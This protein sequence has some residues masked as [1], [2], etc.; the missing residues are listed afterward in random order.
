MFFINVILFSILFL[1]SI[2]QEEGLVKDDVTKCMRVNFLG[3]ATTEACTAVTPTLE[4][5][6]DYEGKCCKINF[7]NDP[8]LTYKRAFGD[9]WKAKICEQFELD[10]DLT[11]D[12]IREKLKIEQ[13]ICSILT[14]IGKNLAL[15]NFALAS[16]DG[17]VKYDCGD[18]EETFNS[19]DFIPKTDFEKKNKDMADCG[20]A[21]DE[22]S[23]N[24]KSS[25]LV[26]DDAQCC[27]CETSSIG[28]LAQN[29]GLQNCMGLPIKEIEDYLKTTIGIYDEG[30][31]MKTKMS[32]SCLDKKGKSTSILVNSATGEVIID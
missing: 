8:L 16:L 2:S 20:V 1:Q 22:K 10:E 5:T 26:T 21:S 3:E 7:V 4:S 6:G 25:K 31:G 15:Y 18:G 9:D 13:K 12:E 30:M 29:F 23:C 27:W 17:E 11:E 14:K 19:K 32:C 24:K 28:D